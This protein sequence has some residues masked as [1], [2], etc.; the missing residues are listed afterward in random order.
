MARNKK[1]TELFVRNF[2]FGVEDSLVSTV[3]FISGVA[4]GGLS[5][6]NIFLAGMVLIFVE[7]F[8]MG[9]GS[10]LSEDSAEQFVEKK[11]DKTNNT[12]FAAIIMFVSYFVCGMIPLS[13]YILL[14]VAQ[15][16]PLSNIFSLVALFLLGAL[17]ARYFKRN[18]LIHGIKMMVIGGLAIGAGIVVATF[19]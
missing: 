8:S 16:F 14:P 2:I 3:G 1:T 17:S 11:K 5:K 6:G 19:I 15:A 12:I 7:A 4:T 9:V 13:P 18:W 10:Y